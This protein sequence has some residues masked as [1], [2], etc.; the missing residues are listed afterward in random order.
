VYCGLCT[1]YYVYINICDI[2]LSNYLCSL[3]ISAYM[4]L[5]KSSMV[6]KV[7]VGIWE[8]RDTIKSGHLEGQSPKA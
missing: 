1:C 5:Y 2:I 4:Q 7:R 8:T 3:F 6:S